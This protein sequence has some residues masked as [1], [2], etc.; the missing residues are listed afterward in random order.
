MLLSLPYQKCPI[1][2]CNIL[3]FQHNGLANNC[4]SIAYMKFLG[5][6]R[7]KKKQ[8]LVKNISYLIHKNR[9]ISV[10]LHSIFLS[11]Y[12]EN[13]NLWFSIQLTKPNTSIYFII[14]GFK[15]VNISENLGV[16]I[17]PKGVS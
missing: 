12:D 4:W 10:E 11:N 15:M 2:G 7:Q 13:G 6:D 1:F 5:N 3:K 9:Q 8:A 16:V 14:K 17:E